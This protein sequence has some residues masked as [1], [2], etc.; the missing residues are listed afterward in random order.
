MA[1]KVISGGVSVSQLLEIIPDELLEEIALQ[2]SADKWVKKLKASA[3]FKLVLFTLLNSERMSL[4]VMESNTRD[5]YF[6]SIYPVLNDHVRWTGIRD[7]LMHLPLSYCEGL[8]KA[9]YEQVQTHYSEKALK[10][11]HI[12]RYDSTMISTFAHLFDGMQVGDMR[13]HKRQ[14]KLTTEMCDD[15]LLKMHFYT[16]QTHVGEEIA[17]KE[18]IL[19]AEHGP[20]EI[21]VFDRGIKSR[22]TFAAFDKAQI[23]Y[24]SRLSKQPR[25]K[26]LRATTVKDDGKAP[27]LT[28]LSDNIV[29]L[30]QKGNN[31]VK[32]ELRMIQYRDGEDGETLT[33]VTNLMELP[34]S[35]IAQIYR[36]RWDIEVLFRFMK[37]ELNLTHFV[38]NDRNAIQVMLYFT[39]ITA[40]LVLIYKKKNEIRSY[41]LAKI[42]F[43]K[44]LTATI[45]LVLLE[46]PEGTEQLKRNLKQFIQRE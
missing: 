33:F 42:Q 38:C 40:M 6:R 31:I 7:R 5:P 27:G 21:V 19:A 8:Y 14:V 15:L 23:D 37:Q 13:N 25:F 1:K 28:L 18:A 16:E 43:F 29:Y 30:Y 45:M 34:A 24:V 20:E 2:V 39:L 46:S 17:L 32:T 22:E 41:K 10:K 36:M 4:R 12:K 44:E 9:V 3:V 26:L 11:Y 35:M